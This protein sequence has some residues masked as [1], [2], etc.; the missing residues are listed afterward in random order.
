MGA[1]AVYHPPGSGEQILTLHMP[2]GGPVSSLQPEAEPLL[3]L[4]W[5][6]PADSSV[7]VFTDSQ[8]LFDSLLAHYMQSGRQ[9]ALASLHGQIFRIIVD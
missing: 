6:I 3:L 7:V 9:R 1:C 4:I 8:A 2:V 5:V